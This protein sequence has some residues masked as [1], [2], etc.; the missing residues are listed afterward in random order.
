MP[1]CSNCGGSRGN[2]TNGAF[3]CSVCGFLTP[4]AGAVAPTQTVGPTIT[5]NLTVKTNQF[6][7]PLAPLREAPKPFNNI[8]KDTMTVYSETGLLVSR[9]VSVYTVIPLD[10]RY[11][12]TLEIDEARLAFYQYLLKQ[13]IIN[14]REAGYQYLEENGY[15]KQP[16]QITC[17]NQMVWAYSRGE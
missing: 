2:I 4:P 8:I 17:N 5:P 10:P 15:Q 12:P 13:E 6:V 16:E 3:Y 11:V 14:E 1:M 7:H 9:D